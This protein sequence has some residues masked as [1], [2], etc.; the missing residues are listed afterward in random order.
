VTAGFIRLSLLAWLRDGVLRT[1]WVFARSHLD[2]GNVGDLARR[3]ADRLRARDIDDRA[4]PA[5]LHERVLDRCRRHPTRRAIGEWTYGDLDRASA[6]L[7][8]ELAATLAPEI[9]E[10]CEGARFAVLAPPGPAAVAGVLA[11]L[12]IGATYVPLD[13]AWPVER[14]LQIVGLARPRAVVVAASA[15]LDRGPGSV[16]ARL[17]EKT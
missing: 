11:A 3:T 2:E 5:R 4:R 7:S 15:G 6:A 1:T 8:L 16:V 14:V 13:P 17:P 9:D 10:M 12:R